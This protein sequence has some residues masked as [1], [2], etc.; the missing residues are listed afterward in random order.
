MEA[1]ERIGKECLEDQRKLKDYEFL[2]H[3]CI[4]GLKASMSEG[5]KVSFV[6]NHFRSRKQPRWPFYMHGTSWLELEG[7]TGVIKAAR[8]YLKNRFKNSWYPFQTED[9]DNNGEVD[10]QRGNNK[11]STSLC[12][13]SFVP[14]L[15]TAFSLT[16]DIRYLRKC[17]DLIGG[18]TQAFPFILEEGFYEDHDSYFG[19]PGNETLHVARRI[20][21]WTDFIYC[22]ALQIEGL[23]SDR[24]VFLLIKQI[25]FYA[26]QFNRLNGD[27][28]RRDNHHLID[29]GQ[30]L[31]NLGIMF[32]EFS[33]SKAMLSYGQ[34][35]LKH[36]IRM[37]IFNDGCYAEHST[38]YQYH[39]A[40]NYLQPLAVARANNILLLSNTET[41]KLGKWAAFFAH[42]TQP[43]GM[44]TSFGD[45]A[46]HRLDYFFQT[47]IPVLNNKRITAIGKSLGY[48][49]S[50]MVAQSAEELTR[51]FS[52]WE[53]GKAP[54]NGLTP[55]Y[56]QNPKSITL[57]PTTMS[58][59][60]Q[61]PHGGFTMMR[62]DWSKKAD[63]LAV[64]HYTDSL[65]H[66]HAHWDMMSFSLST[67]S[68]AIIGDPASRL[69]CEQLCQK[70]VAQTRG[71]TYG[72]LS[73]NCLMVNND[74]LKTLEALGHRTSW[75]GYPP[76]HKLGI[77]KKTRKLVLAE[78][79]HDAFYPLRHRRFVLQIIGMGYVMVDIMNEERNEAMRPHE[80]K[81]LL[82]F[83]LGV[84]V[85]QSAGRNLIASK[86]DTSMH[87][88]PGLESA[89]ELE[90]SKD[91]WLTGLIVDGR[92]LKKMP[93]VCSIVRS[94]RDASV[95]A[96][97]YVTQA[98]PD[99]NNI[100]L[101]SLNSATTEF[102]SVQPDGYSAHKLTIKGK[103]SLLLASS[104][105]GRSVDASGI[106]TD[107]QM[108]V[109]YYDRH[110]NLQ[111]WFLHDGKYIQARGLEIKKNRNVEFISK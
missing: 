61:Y 59:S 1:K 86:S 19:G 49:S 4:P 85:S 111:D 31:V 106:K 45:G 78:L 48:V 3:L 17:Y 77:F 80:Y 42:A 18:F 109:I 39:I 32:P 40:Y 58:L 74:S 82:H 92:K 104:P 25:W 91:T 20:A 90:Q 35:T 23:L 28:M 94:H 38:S 83:D 75:G 10:W 63:F 101:E 72:V 11:L 64:S 56:D 89:V 99:G 8:A 100:C 13:N 87:I 37:N 26:Y 43:D 6:A 97:F 27:A 73:H 7:R 76:K 2:K 96:T 51:I 81:Q 79:Y 5:E 60:A 105:F 24:E 66:C 84:D 110:G 44:L 68:Q 22:G 108:A 67:N 16:G 98:K 71:Y 33:E 52:D 21:R 34:K 53:P 70:D 65:P 47:L 95:F 41:A 14:D 54:R 30:T 69:Y 46:G 29:H 62:S 55:F 102:R 50:G 12:R 15:T 57:S 36:H 88:L 9:L 103:G 107:A 93:D